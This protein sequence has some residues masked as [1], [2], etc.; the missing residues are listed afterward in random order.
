MGF[1]LFS[2][3]HL[4]CIL[5]DLWVQ[6]EH[7]HMLTLDPAYININKGLQAK[8][9]AQQAHRQGQG[10]GQG[11]RDTGTHTWLT[12]VRGSE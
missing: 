9:Q 2:K 8:A 10:Q 6:C 5:F 1:H 4:E 7:M 11:H 12:S 3:E